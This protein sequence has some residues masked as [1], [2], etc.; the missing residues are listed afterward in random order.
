[1]AMDNIGTLIALKQKFQSGFAKEGKP[2]IVVVATVI[3][4][5]IEE[6]ILRVGFNKETE[7]TVY[8]TAIDRTVNCT[9][10]PGH[11][12]ITIG[13][14]ESPNMVIPHTVVLRQ[15]NLDAVTPIF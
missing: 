15:N 3:T 13:I 1:M 14:V 9:A 6:I 7:P 8:P 11:P 10:I 5:P 2:H 12:Q 4:A